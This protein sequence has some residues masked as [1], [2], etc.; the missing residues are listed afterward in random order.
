MHKIGLF[1]FGIGIAMFF[2]KDKVGF[3]IVKYS[4]L[5]KQAIAELCCDTGFLG[6]PI[7]TVF[8]DRRLFSK[9]LTGYY[10]N[11]EPNLAL[12]ALDLDGR[13]VGYL[14]GSARWWRYRLYRLTRSP[15]FVLS[16]G[17]E[18]IGGKYDLASLK[19]CKW[20]FLKGWREI[21][22]KPLKGAHFHF[23]IK[24]EWRHTG[25]GKALVEMFLKEVDQ[26]GIDIVY[27]QMLT[28]EKRRTQALYDRLGW[29]VLDRIGVT[30][31]NQFIDGP[32]YL[33]TI[34]RSI[35]QRGTS[36]TFGK[37]KSVHHIK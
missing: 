32:V 35:G 5:F 6:K 36:I 15:G 21:P 31:F 17:W 8:C 22:K 16:M 14:L 3:R 29:D 33:S 9:Y 24:K 20:I 2:K 30:K 37:D 11:V 28:F 23:N 25:V 27:G 19:F 4:P 7:D 18:I 1:F 10:I 12:V 34:C 13:V 26:H